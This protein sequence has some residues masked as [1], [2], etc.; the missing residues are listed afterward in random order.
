AA[1]TGKKK[2]TAMIASAGPANSQPATDD[3]TPLLLLHA[4][5]S[6]DVSPV[7][8]QSGY[9]FHAPPFGQQ[10]LSRKQLRTA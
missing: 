1:S 2:K 7:C 6:S 5:A 10:V 4:P 3:F 9:P 8:D